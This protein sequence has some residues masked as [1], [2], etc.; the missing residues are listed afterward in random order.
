MAHLESTWTSEVSQTTTHARLLSGIL[1]LRCFV[2]CPLLYYHYKPKKYV[3][4]PQGLLNSLIFVMQ[5]K[6]QVLSPLLLQAERSS[7]GP[8]PRVNVVWHK[9]SDLRQLRLPLAFGGGESKI[10]TRAQKSMLY[11]V[12]SKTEKYARMRRD[13]LDVWFRSYFCVAA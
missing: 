12:D 13:H 5:G 8:K 3:L 2:S 1:F 7:S 11:F 6:R 9:M 10:G 4:F